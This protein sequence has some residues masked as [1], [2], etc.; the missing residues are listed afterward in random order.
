MNKRIKDLKN[1]MVIVKRSDSCG[2]WSIYDFDNPS[3]YAGKTTS[4]M[5]S[6]PTFNVRRRTIAGRL[7]GKPRSRILINE[8]N[9]SNGFTIGTSHTPVKSADLAEF[10]NGKIYV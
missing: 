4:L 6:C 9:Y 2:Y 10:R 5:L 1:K 7:K 8:I 3:N